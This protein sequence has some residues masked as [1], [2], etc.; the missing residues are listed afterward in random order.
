M[1]EP[2]QHKL[3][4]VLDRM[5]GLYKLPDLLERIGDGRMQSFVHGQSW[6]ITEINV[7]PHARALD[8]VAAIGDLDDCRVLHDQVVGFADRLNIPLIRAFGRRGWIPDAEARGWRR[9]TVNQ[10]YLR[11]M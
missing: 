1:S 7:F 4:R 6:A 2:Y 5:G 11:E 3:E 10:V 9:L 8:I